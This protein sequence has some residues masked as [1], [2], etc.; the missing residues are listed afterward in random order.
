MRIMS[1]WID[2]TSSRRKTAHHEA[3]L[4]AARDTAD[5]CRVLCLAEIKLFGPVIGIRHCLACFHGQ[6]TVSPGND[7]TRIAIGQ[8]WEGFNRGVSRSRDS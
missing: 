3:P 7:K 4:I 5:A 1:R 8:V 6:L 2:G